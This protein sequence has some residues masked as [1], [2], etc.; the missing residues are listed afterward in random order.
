MAPI[1]TTRFV[2]PRAHPY[3]RATSKSFSLVYIQVVLDTQVTATHLHSPHTTIASCPPG[4][5]PITSVTLCSA[6]AL[7]ISPALRPS[8]CLQRNHTLLGHNGFSVNTENYRQSSVGTNLHNVRIGD[9]RKTQHHLHQSCSST[10]GTLHK[11]A[12]IES[13]S[14]CLT[15]P[16]LATT[17]VLAEEGMSALMVN[18]QSP[19]A[20][21]SASTSSIHDL[22]LTLSPHG[23]NVKDMKTTQRRPV[24]SSSYLGHHSMQKRNFIVRS[25]RPNVHR[26]CQ[27]ED[28]DRGHKPLSSFPSR[29]KSLTSSSKQ[30]DVVVCSRVIALSSRAGRLARCHRICIRAANNNRTR[31]FPVFA[32]V[33]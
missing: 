11:R 15:S 31:V 29:R 19:C 23:E 18:M 13:R 10:T 16:S 20:K 8:P 3:N 28:N 30:H 2:R 6:S 14:Q 1:R 7:C 27:S 24:S 17:T 12:R 26:L 4:F 21:T 22:P 25:K 33:T 5:Q 9:K 32:F